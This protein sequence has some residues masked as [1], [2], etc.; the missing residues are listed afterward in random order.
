MLN[1]KILPGLSLLLILLTGCSERREKSEE[2]SKKC[3]GL[4]K[5]MNR[6][7]SSESS[8]EDCEDFWICPDCLGLCSYPASCYSELV[9]F[10]HIEA[11]GIGYKRGYSTLGL[12]LTPGHLLDATL[13][14]ADLRGEVFDNA[15]YA[16]NAGLGF[17]Y[18][19]PTPWILGGNLFYDYRRTHHNYQ[20][21]GLGLEFLA[22][23]FEARANGYLPIG[24]KKHRSHHRSVEF[25]MKGLGAEIGAHLIRPTQ[26]Y[27]LYAGVGP[28]YYKGKF[29]KQAFGG[30]ARLL[31][32]VP[33]ISIELSDSYDSLFHNKFQGQV[34]LN[35]AFGPSLEKKQR[36]SPVYCDNFNW[37]NRLIFP[38]QRQE[39]I[40]LDKHRH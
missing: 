30:K 29:D 24:E 22:S 18:L 20:Q 17:R 9:Y 5:L 10:K 21:I 1:E 28:Y 31:L 39:I 26:D 4:Q 25:A 35:F 37:E 33:N 7:K 27:T 34:S 3:S 15:K 32:M 13:L 12:F 11:G 14:F 23:R 16:G 36:C 2:P 38:V 40:V 6:C 8:A 19:F